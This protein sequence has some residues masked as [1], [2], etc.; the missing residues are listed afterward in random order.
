MSWMYLKSKSS[1]LLKNPYVNALRGVPLPHYKGEDAQIL[2]ARNIEERKGCLIARVGE[3]EGRA[4]TYYLRHRLGIPVGLAPYEDELKL[5]IKF[6]A[7][8]FPNNDESVDQLARLYVDACSSIDIYAAWTRHDALLCP[9]R[10][11]R[12]RLIDLDPFFTTHRWTLALEGRRVC[13]V[14][15]FIDTMHS[16]YQKRS[17][18]FSMPVI[19]EMEVVYVRAP[20]THCD[21]S[22]TGQNWFRNLSLLTDMVL[23]SRAEVVIIGAGAYGL[24]LG[25]RIRDQGIA[26]IVLGGSTQLLFGIKGNRWENDRQYRRIFNEHWV[27]PSETERPPGFQKVEIKGGAYW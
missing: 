3:N 13:I 17:K 25:A 24:P 21:T 22:T 7:G 27:R 9:S 16:Q 10:A 20:M 18:I 5:R 26:A 23:E 11:T 6:G 19:P 2:I 8:Y 4:T 12:V 1:T 14:S 15:P